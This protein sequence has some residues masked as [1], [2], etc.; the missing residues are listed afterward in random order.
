MVNTYS[1]ILSSL[2]GRDAF[3]YV[4]LLGRKIKGRDLELEL[5]DLM[6]DDEV[7]QSLRKLSSRGLIARES[8]SGPGRPKLN[9]AKIN[10]L[11]DFLKNILKDEEI[12][13]TILHIIKHSSNIHPV[14]A[15][16][17]KEVLGGKSF[18]KEKSFSF[19]FGFFLSFL[20]ASI[21]YSILGKQREVSKLFDINKNHLKK[22][23]RTLGADTNVEKA[24][25]LILKASANI[26]EENREKLLKI[27]KLE[28]RKYIET[29]ST[30]MTIFMISQVL[31]AE[32]A[33]LPIFMP[34]IT[35]TYE[36]NN[37]G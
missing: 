11:E 3:V 6:S 31:A 25:R 4:M 10:A 5:K 26:T 15:K 9:T 24:F 30:F 34:F 17:V 36:R 1:K 21:V 19:I 14:F 22:L 13:E 28:K 23:L 35:E 18:I 7:R 16:Y 2:V 33:F 29:A 20:T 27:F 12:I 37:R 8:I 32:T